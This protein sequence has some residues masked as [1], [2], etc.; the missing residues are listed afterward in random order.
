METVKGK[1]KR[2]KQQSFSYKG[3]EILIKAI[4]C[5]VPT[6]VMACFKFPKKMYNE[7][8][9]S[10]ANFWWGQKEEERKI[11]W[12]GWSKKTMAKSLGRLG[13]KD[14]VIFNDAILT[15]QC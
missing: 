6:Y 10:I 5:V 9:F 1:L 13:F 2:W 11:Q 3:K 15:K 14:L 12:K 4:A 8:N 7:M